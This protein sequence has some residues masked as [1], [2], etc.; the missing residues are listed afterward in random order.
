MIYSLIA[1][2]TCLEASLG[3]INTCL[4]VMRPVFTKFADTP[5]FHNLSSSFPSAS[6]SSFNLL[7]SSNRSSRSRNKNWPSK[8][9][10][11]PRFVDPKAG[12]ILFSHTS[13]ESAVPRPPPKSK[14]YE[15]ARP[16]E[17]KGNAIVVQR[18]WDVERGVGSEEGGD[19]IPLNARQRNGQ[20]GWNA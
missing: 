8:H 11:A 5:F 18:D 9:D 12:R 19:R 13:E 1:L 6:F 15:P 7:R 10:I 4:P 16:W 14:Y 3:V 20:G 2:L 17:E